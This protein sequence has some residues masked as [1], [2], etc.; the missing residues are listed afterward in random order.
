MPAKEQGERALRFIAVY[1]GRCIEAAAAVIPVHDGGFLRGDGAFEVVAVLR[2]R[3][4]A[5]AEHLA[6][7]ELSC[8]GLRIALPKPALETD[9]D[10]ALREMGDS[11]YVLRIIV[12][13]SGRR[14]VMTEPWKT[15]AESIRL[16]VVQNQTAPLLRGLKSLSYAANMLSTRIAIERGFDEALWA[17]ADG[18][19][20]EAPTAAFF[21]V[22]T[23][24]RLLT[25]P[26]SD[27][28]LDSITRRMV[29][30]YLP[31]E[32]QSCFP[33][34]IAVSSEAFLAGTVRGIQAVTAVDTHSLGHAPGAHTRSA[35]DIY[36]QLLSGLLPRH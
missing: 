8:S 18:R 16:T 36:G 10:T 17:T 28:I 26:L 29:L 25:P 34:D 31:A 7:L 14:L 32:E 20:L 6:R 9:I 12:T 15:P 1:E 2:G 4:F 33:E 24:N 30:E 19:L 21:W 23:D 5:L 22:S 11:T 35:G 13:V 3:P 27:G